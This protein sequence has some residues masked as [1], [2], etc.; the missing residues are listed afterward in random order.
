MNKTFLFFIVFSSLSVSALSAL[1]PATEVRAVWLTTNYGL[2]WPGNR[3]GRRAQEQELISILDKLHA[4]HFNT[5]LFQVRTRGEVLYDSKIE[6]M[7][8]VVASEKQGKTKFDPLAF[9]LEECHKRGMELHAWL[10]TY[11]LGSDKQVK[12]LGSSSITKKNPS[13]VKKYRNEWFLDPG[14][15]QTDD[16]LMSL[17]EELVANYDID[18]IHF[19]YI[20]YPDNPEGFPDATTHRLYGKG[21]SLQEWRRNNIS[22]F[23]TRVYDRIKSQKRWVQVSSAPVGRYRK[24]PD[25][26]VGWT[27]L[28]TVSQDAVRWIKTGKHDALYPMI[29]YKGGHF[30]PFADDWIENASGRI[31]VPGLGA[32]RMS[33]A[34]W[35]RQDILNQIDYTRKNGSAGQSYF[36]AGNI[37]S[38]TKGILNA[39][40]RYY[41]N[42]AK[43]PAMIW[44]S[45]KKPDPPFDLTAEKVNGKLRL[46]WITVNPKERVTYN[47]YRSETSDFEPDK[48]SNILATGLREPFFEY[49]RRNDEKGYYYF[50]TVSDSYHNESEICHPAFFVH[51]DSIM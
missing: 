35:S 9:V 3:V 2:D 16:Y 41:E 30:Y 32:Y 27:A 15:P 37:L 42:P 28:E 50:V 13:I 8:S 49:F 26:V 47:V 33:D 51:S 43:L 11:P 1:P 31:V 19:D 21:Q 39:L 40:E 18:G 38:N 12:S 45:D 46:K 7:A 6:P 5:V 14:N 4:L 36:R 23:V 17:V 20:R 22:R 10:V 44:L 24:L 25:T 29:Y 48:A 34:A